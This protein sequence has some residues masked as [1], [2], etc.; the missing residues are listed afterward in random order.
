MRFASIHC[1]K[2]RLRPTPL[3]ELTAFPKPYSCMVLRG[4]LRGGDGGGKERGEDGKGKGGEGRERGE[5]EGSEV[6]QGR[7]LAKAAAEPC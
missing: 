6:G 1:N 5:W 7:R 4:P 3:G 2:M